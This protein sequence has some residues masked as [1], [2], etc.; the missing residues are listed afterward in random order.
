MKFK[1][2]VNRQSTN[3]NGNRR[4]SRKSKRDCGNHTKSMN[5]YENQNSISIRIYII[6]YH[7]ISTNDD[8]ENR[9]TSTRI[10]VN[11]RE[12]M[13]VKEGQWRSKTC[14]DLESMNVFENQRTSM[15]SQETECLRESLT[16]HESMNINENPCKSVSTKTSANLWNSQK[17]RKSM[18]VLWKLTTKIHECQ[19][20]SMKFHE[21]QRINEN[22]WGS[23]L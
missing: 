4:E 12:W 8:E 3:L 9:W 1:G 2:F 22:Q 5:V 6:S 19:R 15:K 18:N 13:E 10:C 17:I 7:I 20:T 11:Q 23:D 16:I 14:Y 21:N